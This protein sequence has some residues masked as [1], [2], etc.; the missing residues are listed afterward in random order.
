[1][2][3]IRSLAMSVAFLIRSVESQLLFTDKVLRS[4]IATIVVI[5]SFDAEPTSLCICVW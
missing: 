1:M 4:N 3:N 5:F 2:Q